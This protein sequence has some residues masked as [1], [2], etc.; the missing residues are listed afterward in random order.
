MAICIHIYIFFSALKSG[1][2]VVYHVCQADIQRKEEEGVNIN[3]ILSNMIDY[4]F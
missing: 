4:Q 1:L 3:S 2:P